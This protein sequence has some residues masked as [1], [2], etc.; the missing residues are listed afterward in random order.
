MEE[1]TVE[2]PV[3]T[4]S[5]TVTRPT[6]DDSLPHGNSTYHATV[7]ND[8]DDDY[9]ALSSSSAQI[10]VRDNDIPT[11]T[12]TSTTSEFL[13]GFYQPM[14]PFSRTGDVSGSLLLNYDFTQTRYQPAPLWE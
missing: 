5:V 1:I 7:L 12:G 9:I 2:F 4:Q 13:D 11:V 3:G 6:T 10:W 8:A 14:L